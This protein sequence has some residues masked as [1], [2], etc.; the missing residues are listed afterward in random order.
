LLSKLVVAAL[1][2]SLPA[3][4]GITYTCSAN[5]DSTDPN[6]CATLN[7]TVAGYYSSTFSNANANIYITLGS[8]GLGQSETFNNYVSYSAYIAALTANPNQDALQASALAA[9]NT[10]DSGP[11]GSGEVELTAALGSALGFTDLTGIIEGAASGNGDPCTLGVSANCYNGIITISNTQGL[12]YDDQGGTEFT[13][14]FD[15]YAVVQ[16]ET[17][18]VLGTASCISTTSGSGNL[19][20]P[21][22]S[23]T[24]IN[25]TPSAVDLF[26]FNSSGNLA[27]NSACVGLSSCPSG[28]YFSYN[29]GVT[30][31]ADGFVYNT[32]ANGDDYADFAFSGCS[33]PFSIQ[34]AVSCGANGS[35][36]DKGLTILNDGGAE[37]NILNAVGF[38]LAPEPATFGLFGISL[39]I[40]GL[41]RRRFQK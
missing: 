20:D 32:S 34:G 27:L 9:L 2:A 8:T 24:H 39:A 12:Y 36:S 31:G 29:G 23:D 1:L 38:D 28:A 3:F 33:G 6:A 22:D 18:E 13:G 25:G 10:Y 15:F 40:L 21:C 4:A 19:T 5:I 7:S 41:A 35:P 14:Q 37:I 30:N 26:R 16:H 11:Y 17:D